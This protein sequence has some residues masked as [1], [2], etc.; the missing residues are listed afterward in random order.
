[1]RRLTRC[2]KTG[3][4]SSN[5]ECSVGI[6]KKCRGEL[7]ENGREGTSTWLG[8]PVEM[9]GVFSGWTIGVGPARVSA[10]A[11]VKVH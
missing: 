5:V 9:E 10:N 4:E 11:P 7:A 3:L 8:G 1:M 6:C 2:S